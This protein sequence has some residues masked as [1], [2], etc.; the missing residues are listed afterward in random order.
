[1]K[2]KWEWNKVTIDDI[3]KCILPKL[4]EF[5]KKKWKEIIREGRRQGSHFMTVSKLSPEAIKR[6]KELKL[7]DDRLFSFRFMKRPRMW[8]IVDQGIYNV[9]W[10]DPEHT[11]FPNN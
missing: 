2:G 8:G 1:M 11:V 3:C 5:E 9:L 10:W 7:D 6:L 4:I